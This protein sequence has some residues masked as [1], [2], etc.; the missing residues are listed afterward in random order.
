[1]ASFGD[2]RYGIAAKMKKGDATDVSKT[3]SY[4]NLAIGGSSSGYN[5][6]EIIEFAEAV[7]SISGAEFTSA[8]VTAQII[9]NE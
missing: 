5:A 9:I 2:P 7:A 1:M 8:N 4:V 6:D 3:I